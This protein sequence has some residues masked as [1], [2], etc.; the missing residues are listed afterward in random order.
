MSTPGSFIPTIDIAGLRHGGDAAIEAVARQIDA[1]FTGAGFCYI[2]N[3]GVPDEVIADTVREARDFFH[4][5]LAEKQHSA[6]K[7]SVRGFNAIGRTQMYGAPNPDYKEYYQIGLELPRD[8]PAVLAGQKLR[9]PNQWPPGRPG[10]ETALKSYFAEI[11][12]CGEALLGAI[13]LCLG[14]GRDFFRDKYDKPLQRTQIIYYP[15][16]PAEAPE[17]QFGVAPHSDYGC[18]TL[19]WQDEVGGLEV[20][21]LE[22]D[23]RRRRRSPARWWSISAICWRVG[24]TIIIARRRIASPTAPA[25]SACRSRPFST[26]ITAPSS[27]RPSSRRGPPN[28]RRSPQAIILSAGST[29]HCRKIPS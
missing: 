20:Q 6:P 28:I 25:A 23:G 7:E 1:A 29:P 21:D 2:R 17:D 8:D 22:G 5:P 3:H 12:L 18:I 10:F 11:A 24:R 14:A 15:P 26:P 9:G 4:L 27:I 19:L 16:H 13:G